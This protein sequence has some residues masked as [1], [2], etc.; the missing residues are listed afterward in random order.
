MADK[1]LL[2]GMKISVFKHILSEIKQKYVSNF[3]HL[4]KLKVAAARHNF[5]WVKN[6]L[7]AGGYN[8]FLL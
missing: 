1:Y 2:F 7:G 5:K 3:T 4:M 6:G 8:I